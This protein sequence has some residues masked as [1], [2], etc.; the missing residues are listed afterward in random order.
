M[1]TW[2]M[3]EWGNIEIWNGE[4]N[5]HQPDIPKRAIFLQAETDVRAFLEII[6]LS[7]DQVKPGQW[8]YAKETGYNTYDP[9]EDD[10]DW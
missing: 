3:N 4:I 2:K 10:E 9:K 1:I 7:H 6:G 5:L 8:G